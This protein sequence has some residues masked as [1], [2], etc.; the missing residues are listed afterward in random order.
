LDRPMTPGRQAAQGV[1]RGG[2]A[3]RSAVVG[4][5]PGRALTRGIAEGAWEPWAG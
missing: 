4:A 5:V 2:R 3:D 1:D